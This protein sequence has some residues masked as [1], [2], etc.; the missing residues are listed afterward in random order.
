MAMFV[1]AHC[2]TEWAKIPGLA[3]LKKKEKKKKSQIHLSG[4]A[5]HLSTMDTAWAAWRVEDGG[6]GMLNFDQFR[7]VPTVEKKKSRLEN[8]PSHILSLLS[9][10]SY[11]HCPLL[12]FP[13]IE[14]TQST[15]YLVVACI[16]GLSPLELVMQFSGASG[17][18]QGLVTTISVFL[19]P[20]VMYFL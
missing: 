5:M 2:C 6:R 8:S 20:K 14:L 1:V 7:E 13:L 18:S 9:P 15:Q 10:C 17:Y 11:P 19:L 3:Y 4:G 16:S 12:P